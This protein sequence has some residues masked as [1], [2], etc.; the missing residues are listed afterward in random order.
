MTNDKTIAFK[1][2]LKS[3]LEK[4]NASIEWTY[5]PCSDLYDDHLI[6]DVDGC[7]VELESSCITPSEL[8]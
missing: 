8:Q 3:L 5:G 2:E 7:I 1:A 4:Y 6:L